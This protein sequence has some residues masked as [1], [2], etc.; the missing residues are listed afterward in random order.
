MAMITVM[1]YV[2]MIYS[3]CV[4]MKDQMIIGYV[5][6][7]IEEYGSIGNRDYYKYRVKVWVCAEFEFVV[8][9][10]WIPVYAIYLDYYLFAYYL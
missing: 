2:L 5:I 3:E 8:S 4:Q 1:D 10:G 7:G 6:V 9:T